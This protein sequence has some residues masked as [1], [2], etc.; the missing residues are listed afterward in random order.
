MPDEPTALQ[1][2]DYLTFR[3]R[4]SQAGAVRDLVRNHGDELPATVRTD[5]EKQLRGV[6]RGVGGEAPRGS[7]QR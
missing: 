1:T 2:D 4:R 3:V 6:E 7:S 5:L